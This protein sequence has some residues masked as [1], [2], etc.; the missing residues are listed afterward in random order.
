MFNWPYNF[1]IMIIEGVR[2]KNDQIINNVSVIL[3]VSLDKT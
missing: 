2:Y 3:M 1:D